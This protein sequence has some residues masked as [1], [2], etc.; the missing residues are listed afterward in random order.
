MGFF[1]FSVPFS[2]P[3]FWHLIKCFHRGHFYQLKKNEDS[4]NF[5]YLLL[6]FYTIIFFIKNKIQRAIL[7][8][9]WYLSHFPLKVCAFYTANRSFRMFTTT[10]RSFWALLLDEL[11]D[12]HGFTFL[13]YTLSF[14][15][16]TPV[17]PTATGELHSCLPRTLNTNV[18]KINVSPTHPRQFFL[19]QTHNLE[20][21][22]NSSLSFIHIPSLNHIQS[23]I[24]SCGFCFFHDPWVRPVLVRPSL[25]P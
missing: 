10:L 25:F 13:L 4:K 23:M 7:L 21:I 6:N 11:K 22:L 16:S 20:F 17:K 9:F 24:L 5:S 14:L 19:S 2:L 12:T 3:L 8:G 15:S 18:P 1:L